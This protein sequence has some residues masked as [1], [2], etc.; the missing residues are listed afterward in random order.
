MDSG[1]G[2]LVVIPW[3]VWDALKKARFLN[4]LFSDDDGTEIA[5]PKKAKIIV[6]Q[7][8]L[9]TV[10]N[11]FIVAFAENFNDTERQPPI[12]DV[13]SQRYYTYDPDFLGKFSITY[14]V[15]A[16][17]TT[18]LMIC[19]KDL[20]LNRTTYDVM[21]IPLRNNSLTTKDT[22]EIW[23]RQIQTERNQKNLTDKNSVLVKHIVCIDGNDQ[24][25]SFFIP[26]PEKEWLCRGDI[27]CIRRS[28]SA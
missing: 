22:N 8:M 14:D 3:C 7:F 18:A 13:E 11:E 26:T 15:L 19:S 20:L 9:P 21:Y 16:T 4:P 12:L 5:V 10:N 23:F 24:E 2:Q 1:I 25:T 27:Y 6:R 17:P 28:E